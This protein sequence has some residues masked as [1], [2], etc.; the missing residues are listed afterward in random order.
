MFDFETRQD[1]EHDEETPGTWR[2]KVNF[3]VAQRVCDLCKDCWKPDDNCSICGQREFIFAG[4]MALND[5]CTW[6]FRVEHQGFTV[7]FL[8]RF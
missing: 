8:I 4:E 6:L 5:F 2:H 3:C 7:C 1:I